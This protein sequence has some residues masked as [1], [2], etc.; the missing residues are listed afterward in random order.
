MA[1]PIIS[2][3]VG[4]LTYAVG[5]DFV[6][7]IGAENDPVA[8]RLG[9]GQLLPP[10]V[11]FSTISG[12]L[13]GACMVPGVWGVTVIASNSD[14][15]SVPEVFT[16]GAYDVGGQY[17]FSKTA[18]INVKTMAVS[19]E[20]PAAEYKGAVAV[21]PPAAGQLRYGDEVVFRLMFTDTASGSGVYTERPQRLAM[22]RFS[23]KGN[24]TEPAFF[25]TPSP[26]F[27]KSV[28]YAAGVYVV[29]YYLFAHI[30][31]Q[32]LQSYLG[33]FESDSGT[34]ANVICE[35]ELE[36]ERPI[37]ASG[38]LTTRMTTQPFLLRISRASI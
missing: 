26:A 27:K 14:G 4:V 13:A 36:F 30:S 2:K 5:Q 33:D 6:F 12:V 38:P 25:V 29:T 16:I 32:A 22:A 35:Y 9:E 7:Q 8:W 24:G 37:G 15:A 3:N 28:E 23:M 10:G 18:W 1:V 20:D 19:F 21:L 31:G 17:S 34:F 11:S